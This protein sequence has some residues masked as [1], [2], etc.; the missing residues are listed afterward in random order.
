MEF[1]WRDSVFRVG[2]CFGMQVE[3]AGDFESEFVV[4]DWDSAARKE[5]G[6][7]DPQPPLA[8]GGPGWQC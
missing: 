3:A 4:R 2:V 5:L 8:A 1:K 6:L 7:W